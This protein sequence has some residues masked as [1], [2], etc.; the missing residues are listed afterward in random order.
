MCNVEYV[1]LS[2]QL[3]YTAK[4]SR[5]KRPRAGCDCGVLRLQRPKSYQDDPDEADPPPI[6]SGIQ[7]VVCKFNW[8]AI[9]VCPGM[10]YDRNEPVKMG[11]AIG[12]HPKRHLKTEVNNL[13]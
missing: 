4:K 5:D 8:K 6:I 9:T 12:G 10:F 2:N 13:I 11:T 1:G 3:Y 7:S